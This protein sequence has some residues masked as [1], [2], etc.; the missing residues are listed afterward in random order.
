M[1]ELLKVLEE[2]GKQSN[3]Q[4]NE[5]HISYSSENAHT[6][7]FYPPR[8][9]TLFVCVYPTKDP[10]ACINPP[11][12]VGGLRRGLS[13]SFYIFHID[14]GKENGTHRARGDT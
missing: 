10:P 6:A 4:P 7:H 8:M 13:P 11:T 2:A 14:R 1:K 12:L 9:Q 5:Y 3:Y